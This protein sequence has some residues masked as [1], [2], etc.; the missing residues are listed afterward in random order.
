MRRDE[1]G[2]WYFLCVKAFKLKSN[3]QPDLSLFMDRDF[4]RSKILL[5]HEN[6][7]ARSVGRANDREKYEKLGTCKLCQIM[8]PPEQLPHKLTM[9]ML[10][11]A[12]KQL[13]VFF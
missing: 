13:K 6:R 8:F 9:K 11:Q 7:Y 5:L 12:E 3:I 1:N 4:S 10:I 2:D